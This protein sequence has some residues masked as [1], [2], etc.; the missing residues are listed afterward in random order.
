MKTKKL[1]NSLFGSCAFSAIAVA[2]CLLSMLLLTASCDEF[3]EVG[4]PVTELNTNA[5]F[6]QKSTANAAMTDIYAR[7]RDNGMLTGK[8][9]GIGREMA[10][11]TD[12]MTWYGSAA[13][14][15]ANFY[16]N[17]VLP[18]TGTVSDWWNQGYSCIYATNAV[19]EG[20]SASTS[21]AQTDKNQLMGEARFV[22]GLLHFYLLQLYGKIPYVTRTDYTV[23]RSLPRLSEN[24]LYEAIIA[25][26][27]IAVELLPA[28]YF[29]PGRVRPSADVAK[30]LLAQVHLNHGDWAEAANYASAV[31]NKTD[32]YVWQE[33]LNAVFLK[34][35]TTAIWQFAPRNATRNTDEGTALIFNSAPPTVAAL[36][37]GLLNAFEPGDLRKENW[38]RT[39]SSGGTTWR[40]S[41]KYKKLGSATPQTEYSIVMRLAELYLIRAEA[42]AEQGELSNAQEDLNKIRNTAGLGN[43]TANSREE[44]LDAVLRERRVE[45]FTE[46]AHRFMDLKRAGKLD[47]YLSDT[48]PSWNT[49]DRLLPLPESE[50]QLNP[51]LLPQNPGY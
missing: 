16:N 7:I 32:V 31:L 42:R 39:R 48:K 24:G 40:H 12:E 6:E 9:S 51:Q 13:V 49:T 33:D 29:T 46:R 19:L 5:V 47:A 4:M 45:L 11:Y 25:D 44:L 17:T 10:L 34:E 36:S 20:V 37:E 18:S 30:A 26:L 3:T 50:L 21:L 27:E 35:S 15:S 14:H 2:F 38:T 43:T 28:D 41:Y 23:N 8:A 22:R 1:Y